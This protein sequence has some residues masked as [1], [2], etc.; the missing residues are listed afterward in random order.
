ME[1]LRKYPRWKISELGNYSGPMNHKVFEYLDSI[2]RT[3]DAYTELG[4]D[5]DRKQ[6]EHKPSSQIGKDC[7]AHIKKMLEYCG[8]GKMSDEQLKAKREVEKAGLQ[9]LHAKYPYAGFGGILQ[10][11]RFADL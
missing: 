10:E 8:E 6:L 3:E 5:R 9:A 7:L 11:K 2:H 1:R 4:Y